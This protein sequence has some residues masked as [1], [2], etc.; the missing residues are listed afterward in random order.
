MIEY[1]INDEETYGRQGSK[2]VILASKYSQRLAV[3]ST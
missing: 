1:S 3:R 2:A